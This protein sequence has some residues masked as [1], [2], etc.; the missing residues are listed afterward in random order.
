MLRTVCGMREDRASAG[1]HIFRE[2][3]KRPGPHRAPAWLA[4]YLSFP[5]RRPGTLRKLAHV[6][7]VDPAELV[8]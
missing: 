7:E 5:Q 2:A 6:L 1:W 8:E 3:C 4:T